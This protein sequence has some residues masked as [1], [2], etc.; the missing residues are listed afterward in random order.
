MNVANYT[1]T[2][3]FLLYSFM[4]TIILKSSIYTEKL[5][6]DTIVENVPRSITTAHYSY[7]SPLPFKDAKIIHISDDVLSDLDLSAENMKLQELEDLITGRGDYHKA[8]FAM[9]YGG[10]QFGNWA[11]QLGDG[12]AIN[13][14]QIE[15][16]SGIWQLQL[17]GSGPTPFSRRGDGFA[18][19]RSS[20]REHL[21]SEAMHY[22]G[23]PTTRSLSIALTGEQV[24]RDMFYDGNA[25]Y[26]KGAVV[27]RVAASFIRFGNFQI[28]AANGELVELRQLADFTIEEHFKDIDSTDPDRYV[29]FFKEIAQATL[30]T[31]MHWQRVGFVH[32]V[33]NTDNLSI[34]GLTIDYGPYGWLDDYNPDWTPNT[35]DNQHKRYRYGAQPEIGLWNLWQL[36]N[37]IYPLI[38]ESKELEKILDS[39][40]KEYLKKHLSM[41]RS[42]LGLQ[43]PETED[44]V[45]IEDVLELMRSHEIDMTLFYRE[46][47]KINSTTD[48]TTAFDTIKS[49]FYEFETMTP[50]LKNKWQDWLSSYTYRLSRETSHAQAR[51]KQMQHTNPKYVLRNYIAQLVI[52]EATKGN[53]QLLNQIHKML[54]K[55]YDEQ[56]EF[57]QWYAKRPDWARNKPGS[58]QLSCSS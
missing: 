44:A 27:C 4:P 48:A 53:Y 57:Q 5:K 41:M 16:N 1:L 51:I 22:L 50:S 58:S 20:I 12:R 29:L 8:S 49:C 26:E 11:G 19:L 13:I 6:A 3:Q 37:A 28:H 33:M 40:K 15:S 35:T 34:L 56:P 21:C 2:C 10:H 24:Y 7:V 25:A 36:A 54:K 43:K 52:D 32:G 31:I 42:K 30:T 38:N 39:Y 45:L 46:L 23:I 9:N 14:G 18:V 47:I 17:K 55:P